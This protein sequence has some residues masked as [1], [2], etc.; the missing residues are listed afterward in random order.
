MSPPVGRRDEPAQTP[1]WLDRTDDGHRPPAVRGPGSKRQFG[2]TWWGRA[3]ID[4]LENR[5]ALDP[6]RLSRGRSYAR[7]GAVRRM[8][9]A[10][11]L[12]MASVQGSRMLPY[13]VTVRVT[14]FDE[15]GWNSLLD[16]IGRQ[17][18]RTA[19]LLDGEV[20]P[21]VVDDVAAAGL[22]L[23][24]GPGEVQPRCSC[25]D[26]ADPCKHAAAVCYLV[27]DALDDDPFT[28]LLLRGRSRT[29]VLTTLRARRTTSRAVRDGQHSPHED[30]PDTVVARDAFKRMSTDRPAIPV[31]PLPPERAGQPVLLA[32]PPPGSGID[33]E[34]LL[35]LAT[36]A[37]QRAW[38]LA[39]DDVPIPDE[40]PDDLRDLSGS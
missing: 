1:W 35:D 10:P 33:A 28:L 9:V 30:A 17:I 14:T 34:A 40:D 18:G 16:T 3:W 6:G 29:D 11:G 38:Q 13:T 5:T 32:E 19:A 26:V 2:R 8:D 22:E 25:P 21:D 12:V 37:A 39:T 31:P 15:R 23:L 4:A 7:R 36:K 20:P 27:A 24:P